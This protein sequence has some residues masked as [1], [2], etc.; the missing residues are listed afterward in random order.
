MYRRN[1]DIAIAAIIAVLGGLAAADHLPGA[2]TIPLGVGLFFAP[3]YLW[4]EAILTQR[5]SGVER[6][7]TS[8]GMALI[9][10]ILG[11]F[12]FF[13]LKIPLFKSAWVGLLVVLTLLGVV[14]VAVQRLREAPAEQQRPRKGQEP[15]RSGLSAVN[16]GI[17]G[18]A[19]AVAI[20]SVAFSVKNAEAQK[21][22][23]LTILGMSAILNSAVTAQQNNIAALSGDIPAQA[24]GI[25]AAQIALPNVVNRAQP[26]ATEAHL[27][28]INHQGV[29]EQY[30]LKLLKKGKVAETWNFTLANGATWQLT[31]PYTVNYSMVANLYLAPNYTEIYRTVGNGY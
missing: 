26:S 15:R 28:V 1:L 5:L 9:F 31:I 18:L 30:R 22:S 27:S 12:L 24:N 6:A 29:P 8:A 13:G 11:G 2:V 14:A 23:G 4:S 10:P 19:A 17:F 20:G 16:A 25:T 7:M 3:G 21:F